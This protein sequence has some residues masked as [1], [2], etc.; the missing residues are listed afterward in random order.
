MW[1]EQLALVPSSFLLWMFVI[2]NQ[3]RRSFHR[4]LWPSNVDPLF[5]SPGWGDFSSKLRVFLWSFLPN[6]APVL[7]F[8]GC[9]QWRTKNGNHCTDLWMSGEGMLSAGSN[10]DPHFDSPGSGG[11]LIRTRQ[12]YALCLFFHPGFMTTGVGWSHLGPQPPDTPAGV[13]ELE[14]PNTRFCGNLVLLFLPH[15]TRGTFSSYMYL[16]LKL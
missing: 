7:F 5:G 13:P 12:A 6:N 2:K 15:H 9:L 8:S 16:W 11:F 4:D 3:G 14:L 1:I 10:A